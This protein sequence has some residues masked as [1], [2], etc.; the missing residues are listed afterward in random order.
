MQKPIKQTVQQVI[1][2]LLYN[3]EFEKELLLL[4]EKYKITKKIKY[5]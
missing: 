4:I 5:Y 2:R 3:E 1:D